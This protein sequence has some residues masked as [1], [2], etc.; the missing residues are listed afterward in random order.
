M[1]QQHY[2]FGDNDRAAQRLRS[3]A[4]VYESTSAALLARFAGSCPQQVADLGAGLGFTTRLVHEITGARAT[5]GLDASARYVALANTNAPS[6]IR[7]IVHDV[8]QAPFPGGEPDFVYARFLL[9][10]LAQPGV[11]LATWHEASAPSAMLVLEETAELTSEHPALRRYY[12][13]VEAMQEYYG[14]A[15]R[16]GRALAELATGSGW[17]VIDHHVTS[18]PISGSQMA[19]LHVENI[20]TWKNDPFAMSHLDPDDV[21][22]V[23]ERLDAI[24]EGCDEASVLAA[25]GQ[26]VAL[27]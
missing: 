10:H 16:I 25:M 4:A 3:L 2:T 8:T 9:T 12:G 23:E 5:I 14:Q 27:R 18:V 22:E 19:K 20:R 13:M 1:S 7:H 24:A 26:L 15:L 6:G 11:V 17:R 21:A